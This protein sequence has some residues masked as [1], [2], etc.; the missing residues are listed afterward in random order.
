MREWFALEP[1]GGQLVSNPSLVSPRVKP[2][3]I[4]RYFP[5]QDRWV[6]EK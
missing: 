1:F 4:D 6:D 5:L 2:P 3:W